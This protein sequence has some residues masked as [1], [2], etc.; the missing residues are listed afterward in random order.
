MAAIKDTFRRLYALQGLKMLLAA[1]LMLE[2]TALV[3][4]HFTKK[5]L[6][7]EAERRAESELSIGRLEIEK[8]TTAVEAVTRNTEWM[9]SE[10]LAAPESLFEPLRKMME[11]NPAIIDGFIAFT[12]DYYADKGHWY[13]PVVARRTSGRFDEMVLGSEDHNYFE[14]DWY[15]RG[16]AEGDGYWSEPYYDES[17]GRTMVV[18]FSTPLRDASGETV[19]VVGADISLAWLTEMVVNIQLYPDSYSTLTSR[20]GKMM[21]SPAETL[22]LANALRY[23][24]RLEGTGWKMSIVIPEDEI[25]GNAKRV[26]M[27]VTLLQLLGLLMLILIIRST[28]LNLLKL[29]SVSDSKDKI[30]NELKIA[31]T[32]QRGM[33]PKTF[34]SYPDRQD[35]DLYASLAPAKEVGGDL[36]DFYIRDNRLVF[37]IGDVSGKG[38]PAA[39]VMAVTRSL[40]RSVSAHESNPG[41]IVSRINEAISQGNDTNMFVTFFFGIL[42]LGSGLLRYCNAGHNAPLLLSGQEVRPLDVDANVPVGVLEGF[43]YS[44]QDATL[45]EDSTLLLYT[46]GLTEAENAG[47]ELFGDERLLQTARGLTALSARDQIARLEQAVQAHVLDAPQSDDL[48]MLCIKYLGADTANANERHLQLQNDIQQ[49]PQLAGFIEDIA[50]ETGITQALAMSLNLALEEAVANVILYAYP[51]GTDGL[52]DIE[53]IIRPESVHFVISD[54]GR[55]FD[56]TSVDEVDITQDFEERPTGGLGIYLVRNLMDDIY[57]ERV[58]GRNL[59]HLS[60]KL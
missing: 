26:G 46:D 38:I 36:F 2:A 27:M 42:D 23:E 39:L 19:G 54:T 17:G 11:S 53:A 1:A 41:R 57:Y 51:D 58:D 48:T 47:K 59:L 50:D 22:T 52:V 10:R 3:Q 44:T 45:S 7:E 30:E 18:T 9:L 34:P 16:I 14:S 28:A 24:T 15:I 40:F 32:I 56:P 29:K 8:V 21:A 55:P 20:E 49:I 43:R 13:E 31:S 4:Y 6:R 37:C 25:Y 33:L 12:P 35:L 60:K 5:G